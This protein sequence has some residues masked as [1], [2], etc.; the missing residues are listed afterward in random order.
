MITTIRKSFQKGARETFGI[1]IVFALIGGMIF[2]PGALQNLGS[3]VWAIRINTRTVNYQSYMREVMMQRDRLNA[4]RAQYGQFAD[5]FLASM[6]VNTD[7]KYLALDTLIKEELINELSDEMTITVH[8]DYIVQKLNDK[9]YVQQYLSDIVPLFVFN[10]DGVIDQGKLQM[11]IPRMGFSIKEYEEKIDNTLSRQ[12]LMSL[13][14][15]TVYTPE[16]DVAYSAKLKNAQRKYSMVTIE[17]DDILNQEKKIDISEQELE[18]YYEL[19]NRLSKKYW[20]PEKRSGNVWK[21]NA[22]DYGVMITDE[23]ID[24]FYEDNKTKKYVDKPAQAVI[25]QITE[26]DVGSLTNIYDDIVLGNFVQWKNVEPFSRGTHDKAIDRAAFTMKRGDISQIITKKDGRKVVITLVDRI[27]RTYKSLPSVKKEIENNLVSQNFKK[28]FVKEVSDIIAHDDRNALGLLVNQRKVSSE[29]IK[30]I[31]RSQEYGKQ[32]FALKK[33]EYDVYVD[34]VTGYIV[35]LAGVAQAFEPKL[36]SIKDV[37]KNDIYE[38]RAKKTLKK[39]IESQ[40]Q[41]LIAQNEDSVM[42]TSLGWIDPNDKDQEK[43]LQKQ[44]IPVYLLNSLEKIGAVVSHEGADKG[45]IFILEDIKTST[46][47]SIEKEEL[48]FYQMRKMTSMEGLVA[49]LYRN[50]KIETNETIIIASEEYST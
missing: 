8:P 23:Q 18:D 12:F 45:M 31:V 16:F 38:E 43:E 37:V 5:Y 9:E 35:Q 42:Q 3:G 32:L 20:V 48:D 1:I 21:I 40:K 7:P 13:V 10:E 46:E 27:S 15:T 33:D 11:I 39:E 19:H 25:K 6:G 44:G 49:S 41:V 30:N 17:F 4:F 24:A 50:A 28:Q 36:D 22:N 2:V 47:T 34:G 26:D 29:D 14:G